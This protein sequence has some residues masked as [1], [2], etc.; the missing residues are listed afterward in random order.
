[1]KDLVNHKNVVNFHILS[2]THLVISVKPT[3]QI[4][5]K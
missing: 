2:V 5:I 4:A 3:K 1:M